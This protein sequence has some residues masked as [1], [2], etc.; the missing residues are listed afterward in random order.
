M[1]N[2]I[3]VPLDGS[4]TSECSIE[5]VESIAKGCN[6]PEVL[7]V[8]V[9]E[10]VPVDRYRGPSEDWEALMARGQEAVAKIEKK[11]VADGIAARSLILRGRPAETIVDYAA[12]NNVD[13]IIMSTHGRSGPSRWAFGSVADKI[14]RSSIVPVL[15]AVPKGCRISL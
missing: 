9:T 3:L 4:E 12:R 6:V 2:K 5:H 10:P 8:F 13:L 14:V 7:L 11:L 15:I 1:Y